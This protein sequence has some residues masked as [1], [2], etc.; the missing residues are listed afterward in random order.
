MVVDLA[1]EEAGGPS[2]YNYLQDLGVDDVDIVVR[3][4][5]RNYIVAVVDI[6]GGGLRQAVLAESSNRID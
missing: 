6:R 3:G 2:G 5:N 1:Y 4:G